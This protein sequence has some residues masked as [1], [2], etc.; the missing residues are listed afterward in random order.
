MRRLHRCFLLCLGLAPLLAA[1]TLERGTIEGAHYAIARPEKAWNGRLLLLAHGY[2]AENAPLVADLFPEHLACRTL[3]DEGWIVAKTSYR[4]NGL[5]LAD[6]MAD[7]DNLRAHIAASHGQP[8]LVLLEGE[9]MGGMVVTLLAERGDGRYQGAVAIGAALQL[10]E[11]GAITGV[12]LQPKLP[13]L[14]LTNQSELEGPKNYVG[15]VPPDAAGEVVPPVLFRISRD[16]HV[17]VNQR[18]RL[19]ALRALV[20][21]LEN[22]R[23]ALPAPSSA[24]PRGPSGAPSAEFYDATQVPEPQPSKVILDADRRGFTARVIEVSAVYGNVFIDA[25]PADFQAIGLSPGSYFQLS[26]GEQHYRVRYGRD[27]DSVPRG[28]WV[29]FPNA[30]GFFWLS[31]N[32]ANAASTAGLKEGD[33]VGLRRYEVK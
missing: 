22:G 21:W 13:L 8:Q 3:L 33:A 25:Q 6:A 15:H 11:A 5:I 29:V 28:D 16:G 30:D 27:F 19:L 14:F 26:V 9:S 10:R 17:N 20:A 1:A 2:R 18:E 7:L 23:G 12:N 31:R 4:R 32:W 24:D